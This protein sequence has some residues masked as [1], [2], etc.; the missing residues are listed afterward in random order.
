MKR[1]FAL[2]FLLISVRIAFAQDYG[3]MQPYPDR[4]GAETPVPSGY[5]PFYIS[6]FGRHGSR[7]LSKEKTVLPALN[8]LMQAH[9]EGVLTTYGELLLAKA[10]EIYARSTGM[11]GQLS[12]LGVEEHKHIAYRM[13]KRCPSAFTDSVRVMASVYPRCILSMAASTGE[14]ARLSP[15]TKWSYRVGTR[16]QSIINTRHR[17]SDWVPGV[18]LQRN[19]LKEKLDVDLLLSHL[20]I[21]LERGKEIVGNPYAFFKAVYSIWAGRE[22]IALEP[23]ALDSLLGKEAVKILCASESLSSYRNMAIPNSDSLITDIVRRADVALASAKPSADLRYGH[24]NGFMRLLVQIGMCGYPMD[25]DD[26][27]AAGYCFS[28]KVPL[29]ANFQMIFYR[30][31]KGKVLVKFLINEKEC[32]M[33]AL[34]GGPYY[35][36][37]DV[38]AILDKHCLK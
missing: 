5:K 12:P 25:L 26:D 9:N 7:Y 2:I 27:K 11:W 29:A 32:A 13:V 23:F 19:Y 37:D 34:T 38:R 18:S 8:A 31:R 21:D 3:V 28:D 30:N 6:H 16:Y 20:F 1:T 22:A 33:N 15:S 10:E 36:W 14:I 17:P 24:D 4:P 35:E